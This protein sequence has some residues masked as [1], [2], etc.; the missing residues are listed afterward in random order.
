MFKQSNGGQACPGAL[1]LPALT[2]HE[3]TSLR[4]ALGN[5]AGPYLLF[6]MQQA[7]KSAFLT[8]EF[9]HS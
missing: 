9:H 2:R 5:M 1:V 7:I 6:K 3:L 8:Y 4:T